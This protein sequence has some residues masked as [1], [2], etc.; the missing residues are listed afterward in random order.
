MSN[1]YM[2][3]VCYEEWYEKEVA[4]NLDAAQKLEVAKKISEISLRD[5]IFTPGLTYP[6]STVPELEK[7]TSKKEFTGMQLYATYALIMREFGSG[8]ETASEI[9]LRK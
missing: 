4:N 2:A 7:F 6:C 1:E 3:L 9:A 8:G 5:P